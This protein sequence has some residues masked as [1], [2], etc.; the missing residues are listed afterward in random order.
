M[1][2]VLQVDLAQ[3]WSAGRSAVALANRTRTL[4]P[5]QQ[6]QLWQAV[7]GLSRQLRHHTAALDLHRDLLHVRVW[8]SPV[9]GIARHRPHRPSL[10]QVALQQAASPFQQL[11]AFI[12][13]AVDL[14]HLNRG[15]DAV[16]ATREALRVLSPRVGSEGTALLYRV[17]ANA[18]DCDG[19][20][21]EALASSSKGTV[22]P[23]TACSGDPECPQ[24]AWPWPVDA[25]CAG[26]PGPRPP[27]G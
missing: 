15:K 16:D 11:S 19:R 4:D 22:R 21:A 3:R 13:V 10:L 7:A 26:P 14:C 20:P 17:M 8:P 2:R 9:A 6:K 5:S 25:R 1:L 23:R 24:P 12:D 27:A 18:L